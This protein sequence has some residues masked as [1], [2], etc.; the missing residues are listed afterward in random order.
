MNRT[1]IADCGLRIADLQ[2][3]DCGLRIADLREA[4]RDNL[5]LMDDFIV[6]QRISF[7]VV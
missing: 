6:L 3:A 1:M 2:I 4:R 7:A 5:I